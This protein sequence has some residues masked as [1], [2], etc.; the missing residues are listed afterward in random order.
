MSGIW[1]LTGPPGVGKST[2]ISRVILRLKSSGVIVGGCSTTEKKAKGAR[3]GFEVLNLT[4]GTRGEL[5]SVSTSLGPRVGRYR[6]NLTDLSTVGAVG[7][8]NAAASSEV[9]VIDEV[10]PME[11]VSPEFRRGVR[12]CLNSGKP[13]LAVV[14][15][16]LEDDL[17][18]EMREKA[19]ET[20]AVTV[21]N[22]DH[23]VD[24]LARSILEAAEG[25]KTI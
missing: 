3:V 2:I 10:G 18:A 6:V 15:E 17:L 21:E 25:P 22:R 16:R 9:I 8:A 1:L 4:D 19:K 24:G 12:A 7:L 5:A 23:V 13:I 14:H 11:L 20:I